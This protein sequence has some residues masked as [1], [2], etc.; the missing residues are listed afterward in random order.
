MRH[1]A[2]LLLLIASSVHAVIWVPI[3]SEISFDPDSIT[4]SSD[5]AR[6][7]VWRISDARWGKTYIN[8]ST[9]DCSL[10]LIYT[11]RVEINDSKPVPGIG[12][13]TEIDFEAGTQRNSGMTLSISAGYKD[14]SHRLPSPTSG[15]GRLIARVCGSN[16][17]AKI[18]EI[19]EMLTR[20][21]CRTK[22]TPTHYL[23]SG[24]DDQ[25]YLEYSN[26]VQ[27]MA[28]AEVSCDLSKEQHTK[29]LW[30]WT[31]EFSRCKDSAVK[32]RNQISSKAYAVSADVSRKMRGEQCTFLPGA[33]TQIDADEAN[34]IAWER[35]RKCVRE[36]VVSLD[37]GLS[38]AEV[39][40][41]AVFAQC[42]GLA[43]IS[44]TFEAGPAIIDPITGR[45]LESRQAKRSPSKTRP[46]ANN[47]EG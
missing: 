45:V 8:T 4:E 25:A 40:A 29:L 28:I 32:C 5:T 43:P 12:A 41:R 35:Y 13:I 1:F 33:Q 7:V 42:R 46:K 15:E 11:P 9:I 19:R 39:I 26:L 20:F 6:Q 37:D 17:A 44:S 27:R 34:E 23:C 31:R 18:Q 2:Y 30:G 16:P 14:M 24:M 3:D 22:P 10:D 36:K 21:A 38:S 47:V